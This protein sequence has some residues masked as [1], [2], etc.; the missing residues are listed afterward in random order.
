MPVKKKKGFFRIERG[1]E[2]NDESEADR[3][4]RS[5]KNASKGRQGRKK[6][7]PH[8]RLRENRERCGGRKNPKLAGTTRGGANF[9]LYRIFG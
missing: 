5:Q 8:R 2:T 6:A 3:Q 1:E 9:R 4:L 7:D